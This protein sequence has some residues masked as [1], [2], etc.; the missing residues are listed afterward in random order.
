MGRPEDVGG[1][2]A[3]APEKEERGGRDDRE[4]VMG[5]ACSNGLSEASDGLSDMFSGPAAV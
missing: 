2:A 3:T 5:R 4:E 1:R